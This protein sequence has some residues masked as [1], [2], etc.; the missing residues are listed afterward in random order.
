MTEG[1][2]ALLSGVFD[3]AGLFPPANLPLEEALAEYHRVRHSPDAWLVRNFVVPIARLNEAATLATEPIP[4]S[5]LS[6]GLE[7]LDEEREQLQA[8]GVA[9]QVKAVELP[10]EPGVDLRPLVEL[11]GTVYLELAS[12]PGDLTL[13]DFGLKYRTGGLEAKA[14]PSVEQ[15]AHYIVERSRHNQPW[16]ATAGLH[17]PLRMFRDEVGTQMHG[18]LNLLVAVVLTEVH[19]LDQPEVTQIIAEESLAAF[20]FDDTGIGWGTR[21]A[22]LEQ[23]RQA[24]QRRFHAIG[25][26]SLAEPKQDLQACGLW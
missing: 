26:C 5:A 7:N 24:R 6:R 15:L 16:K 12:V 20:R 14:F 4:F 10:L 23:I 17:H 25:S 3:Y 11:P 19:Q 18:F 22:S 1:L 13:G 8:S 9:N 21:S 2:R